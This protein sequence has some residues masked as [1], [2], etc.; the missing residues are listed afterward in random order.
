MDG[1]DNNRIPPYPDKRVQENNPAKGV[2][3][4]ERV[5]GED[6]GFHTDPRQTVPDH[7][8]GGGTEESVF[9][10]MQGPF[11]ILSSTV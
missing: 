2:T 4:Y 8:A 6:D 7:V 5:V 1:T 10:C 11:R 3:R 9:I